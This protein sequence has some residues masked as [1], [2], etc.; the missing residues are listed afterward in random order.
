[1]A[2]S[3]PLHASWVACSRRPA[4]GERGAH[5]GVRS[6]RRIVGAALALGLAVF[7]GQAAPALARAGGHP[8]AAL[9]AQKLIRDVRAG[10]DTLTP[11]PPEQADTTVEPSIAVNPSNPKIAV[12]CY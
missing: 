12:A 2:L 3:L 11:R 8:S 1:M 6:G 4:E 5:V 9:A 7:A 10:I